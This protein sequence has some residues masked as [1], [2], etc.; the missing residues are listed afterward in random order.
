MIARIAVGFRAAV[1]VG[2]D[3]ALREHRRWIFRHQH[4]ARGGGVMLAGV[5]VCPDQAA[6]QYT[7]QQF[8][9]R[10]TPPAR[11]PSAMAI[12]RRATLCSTSCHFRRVRHCDSNLEVAS[13]VCSAISFS[14]V[15]G[16]SANRS[17]NILISASRTS[18]CSSTTVLKRLYFGPSPS[19]S[20]M[21]CL[22][23]S[24]RSCL[25]SPL[26][27]AST[28]NPNSF[29]RRYSRCVM[30]NPSTSDPYWHPIISR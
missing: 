8:L 20:A 13:M 17:R 6:L 24:S 23:P 21:S 15:V 11:F 25:R 29:A 19:S 12:I 16:A 30:D 28:G 1:S 27:N 9:D 18:F 10:T 3:A 7:L 26:M 2:H 4:D 22:M 14:S 5:R